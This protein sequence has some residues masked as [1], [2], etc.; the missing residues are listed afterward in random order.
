MWRT[1][2]FRAFTQLTYI[3]AVVFQSEAD[4]AGAVAFDPFALVI[5]AAYL[6]GAGLLLLL[7]S[8]RGDRDEARAVV[9]LT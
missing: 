3:A 5:L 9:P 8:L 4:V 6:L 1:G 2:G 7:G